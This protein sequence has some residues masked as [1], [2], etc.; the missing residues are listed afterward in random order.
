MLFSLHHTRETITIFLTL[1]QVHARNI[2]DI[3]EMGTPAKTAAEIVAESR[4]VMNGKNSAL[5]LNT[6]SDYE[7]VRGHVRHI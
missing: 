3:P 6:S 1:K 2:E 5:H 4:G 7:D